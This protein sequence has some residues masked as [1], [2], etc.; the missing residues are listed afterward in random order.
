MMSTCMPL[1]NGAAFEKIQLELG[2][3]RKQL[4]PEFREIG[5][6]MSEL[7]KVGSTGMNSIFLIRHLL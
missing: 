3:E 6:R 1:L 2:K 4:V 5:A 7:W